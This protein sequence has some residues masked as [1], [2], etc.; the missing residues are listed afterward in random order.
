MFLAHFTDV[1]ND[2]PN[3]FQLLRYGLP[4]FFE[5][6]H[7]LIYN[8]QDIRWLRFGDALTSFILRAWRMIPAT[9]EIYGIFLAKE[10]S[11]FRAARVGS[12]ALIAASVCLPIGS[13]EAEL[14]GSGAG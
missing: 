7:F 13:D 10:L 12:I 2:T 11:S 6:L 9:G 1:D 3:I 5:L 14:G 8:H 4:L